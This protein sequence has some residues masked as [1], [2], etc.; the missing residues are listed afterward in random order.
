MTCFS[1]DKQ[2]SAENLKYSEDDQG[3]DALD[4]IIGLVF[5]LGVEQGRR[6]FKTSAVYKLEKMR[7]RFL[8]KQ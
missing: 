2:L 1:P 3:R 5:R 8:D 7:L 4:E 6:I